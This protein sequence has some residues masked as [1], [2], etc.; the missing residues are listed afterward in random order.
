M[1]GLPCGIIGPFDADDNMSESITP[2]REDGSVVGWGDS[3]A[4]SG[5]VESGDEETLFC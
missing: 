5:N 3:D 4:S 1:N 2:S